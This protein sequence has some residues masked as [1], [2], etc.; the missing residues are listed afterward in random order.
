MQRAV[1]TR[2]LVVRNWASCF[3]FFTLTICN[4]NIFLSPQNCPLS[5]WGVV[6][7]TQ[8]LSRV[9]AGYPLTLDNRI[10]RLVVVSSYTG[11]PLKVTHLTKGMIK[12]FDQIDSYFYL[13]LFFHTVNI[14]VKSS[15]TPDK[16][17]LKEGMKSFLLNVVLNWPNLSF[18]FRHHIP[19]KSVCKKTS[20]NETLSILPYHSHSQRSVSVLQFFQVLLKWK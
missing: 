18:E 9:E 19:I 1:T 16:K 13:K 12:T 14:F 8:L 10:C 17:Y 11:P 15:H 2:L 3:P 4:I 20:S 6:L 5:G 7:A